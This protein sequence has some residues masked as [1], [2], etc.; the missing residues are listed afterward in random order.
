MGYK[1]QIAI[2]TN[3][4]E[5]RDAIITRLMKALDEEMRGTDEATMTITRQYL[6]AHGQRKVEDKIKWA[7][8]TGIPDVR[9]ILLLPVFNEIPDEIPDEELPIDRAIRLSHEE[10]GEEE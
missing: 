6:T 9:S 2:T 7:A 4:E 5:R 8:A 10:E 1:I 3:F